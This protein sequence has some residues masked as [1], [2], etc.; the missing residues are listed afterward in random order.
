MTPEQRTKFYD[1]LMDAPSIQMEVAPAL[2]PK[3]TILSFVDGRVMRLVF[4][5]AAERDVWLDGQR[6]AGLLG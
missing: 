2:C 1:A 6:E 4:H 3:G 5:S